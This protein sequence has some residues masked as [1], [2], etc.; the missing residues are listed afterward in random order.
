MLTT[1]LMCQQGVPFQVS[2][3]RTQMIDELAERGSKVILF[4]PGSVRD[5]KLKKKV[6]TIV[7]TS[8]MAASSIRKQIKKINPDVI[9]CFTQEDTQICFSLPYIMRETDF[10]YYNL[11]IYVRSSKKRE[12]NIYDQY[13]NKLDYLQN[14]LKEILYVNGCLAIVVQDKLRKKI[15]KK[16][17]I[18]HV[19]T[20]LIPNSYYSNDNKYNILHKTGL[21]YSG[22]VGPDVLGSF[23]ENA[24]D[25]KN[26]EI[27]ISG[28]YRAGIPLKDNPNI[29]VIK[30]NLSQE[31]YTEF[32]SAYDIALIWYSDKTDENVYNIGLASGKYFKHLSLG[33]PVIV[34]RVPGLAEEIE[35]YKVGVVID[36]LS[37]LENAVETIRA[38]YDTYVQNI[39]RIYDKRYDYQKVSRR[40]FDFVIFHARVKKEEQEVY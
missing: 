27:T 20:W 40:F 21:I 31:K 7:N 33:Q 29:K 23:I 3:A 11:E 8:K 38:D 32:I 25:L 26:V 5:V 2:P 6:E 35:K 30:Q 34:N 18:S 17:W 12:K 24:G 4:F 37:E 15:L 9:I 19:R 16:Y 39:K 10:Y 1:I 22:S 13:I 28:W 14:K 36:S